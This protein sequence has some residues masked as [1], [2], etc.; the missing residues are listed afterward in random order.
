MRRRHVPRLVAD[1]TIG[2]VSNRGGNRD[3]YVN[4]DGSRQRNLTP[5]LDQQAFGI[6]FTNVS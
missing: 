6:A 2:F 1:G 5:G 3:I 4:A